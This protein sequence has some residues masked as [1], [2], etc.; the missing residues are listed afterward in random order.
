MDDQELK[1]ELLLSFYQLT[2]APLASLVIGAI[3]IY[4]T[5]ISWNL[6]STWTIPAI[7]W[8]AVLG[9][10]TFGIILIITRLP[11]SSSL[12]EICRDLIPIFDGLTLWQISI[13]SFLAGV[14]EEL[15]FRGF[16][17]QW[18]ADF[19]AIELA[20]FIAAAIFGLLHFASVGYFLLTTALGL[21]FG[22]VFHETSSLILIMSWHGFYDLLAIWIFT[23]RP[24][25]LRADT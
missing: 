2:L 23:N 7:S 14:G 9:A 18:L 5:D 6:G 16:L 20:I 13:L 17:Q 25:L 1:P 24:D 12:R 15:L 11:F 22:F 3:L 21:L 4:F 8:G 19:V 10:V